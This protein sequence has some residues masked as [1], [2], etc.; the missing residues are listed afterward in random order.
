MDPTTAELQGMAR[1]DDVVAWIGCSVALMA[2]LRVA[3]GEFT[4]VREICLIPSAAWNAAV[5]AIR[6]VTIAA[7]AA[8][9]DADP[10]IVD[11]Q[12]VD[13]PPTALELGHVASLRRVCRLRLGLSA[14]ETSATST[15]IVP[16]Q[17]G[18]AGQG[19]N[20]GPPQGLL[21]LQPGPP[22]L[23]P[24]KIKMSSVIDQGDDSEIYCWDPG[25]VRTTLTAFRTS[26]NGEDAPPEDEPSVEQFSALD[27]KIL[28]G[29]PS[30]CDFG[31]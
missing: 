31:V 21:Q 30:V 9:P 10:P 22:V 4:L 24:R 29:A 11:V 15:A 18:N 16:M 28:Q 8:D 3:A 2:G 25:R 1:L 6:I 17:G 23:P 13:R 7:V 27:T 14:E 12:Q 20:P 19:M 26:N 5:T